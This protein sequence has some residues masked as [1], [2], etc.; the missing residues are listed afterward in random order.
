MSRNLGL[1]AG[2]WN[3]LFPY[4][5]NVFSENGFAVTPHPP[6]ELILST[7]KHLWKLE[8]DH[9]VDETYWF[10]ARQVSEFSA[11]NGYGPD[12]AIIDQ[13]RGYLKLELPEGTSVVRMKG[14]RLKDIP[15]KR[16]GINAEVTDANGKTLE[17]HQWPVYQRTGKSA[18]FFAGGSDG[19]I[20]RLPSVKSGCNS[21]HRVL[22][23]S[24]FD[25]SQKETPPVDLLITAN[26]GNGN[27]IFRRHWRI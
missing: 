10:W 4:Y 14:R 1:T 26:D 15:N 16:F 19:S 13:G 27:E 7:K 25:K 24:T 20:F 8:Q 11:M 12:G 3:Q 2:E 5:V 6:D 21:S 18:K 22:T 9:Y 23:L 17:I